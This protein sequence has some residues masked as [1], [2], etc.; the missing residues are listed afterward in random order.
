MRKF[1]I[2]LST[3][4]S[5]LSPFS[6][7]V[8]QAQAVP[9]SQLQAT[10]DP[11]AQ[12][13]AEWVGL[14]GANSALQQALGHAKEASQVLVNEA[15]TLKGQLKTAQDQLA[16]AQADLKT[17]QDELAA[18]KTAHPADTPSPPPPTK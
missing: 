2:A 6:Y 9:Q 12:I 4:F 15:T 17:A 14:I 18:Y 16:K 10:P 5:F 3:I 11:I 7:A 13:N 8:A 1:S